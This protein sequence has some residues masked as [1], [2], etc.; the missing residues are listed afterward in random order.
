[1]ILAR[2]ITLFAANPGAPCDIPEGSFLGFPAWYRY[3]PGSYE[4][5]GLTCVARI[6]GVNDIWLIVAAVINMLL[7]L[8]SI[9]AIGVIIWAGMQFILSKGEPDKVKKARDTIWNGLVGLA[10]AISATAAVTFFA[11]RFS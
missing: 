11:S 8:A 1:M 10:I 2:F 4:A 9:V 6:N 7:Y 3:L 5:D